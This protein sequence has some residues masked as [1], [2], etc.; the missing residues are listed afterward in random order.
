LTSP[1]ERRAVTLRVRA[2]VRDAVLLAPFL[3]ALVLAIG[4]VRAD[5]PSL[6]EWLVVVAVTVVRFILVAVGAI[7]RRT[8]SD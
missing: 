3:I 2:A 7:P 6:I 5:W 4:Y 8:N 1:V